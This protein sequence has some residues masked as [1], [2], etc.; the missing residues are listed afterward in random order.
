MIVHFQ[1]AYHHRSEGRPGFDS[2]T[3]WTQDARLIFEDA[4]TSNNF[5]DWPC[6]IM[7]GE[8]IVAGERHRNVIP[9]PLDVGVATEL[10]LVCDSAHS[11]TIKGQRV[12]LELI[13]KPRYAEEFSPRKPA[14]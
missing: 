7:D 11:V 1:P 13:G 4:A 8:L 6:D 9:V 5:P 3:C 10:R 14:A 12:R 2:G